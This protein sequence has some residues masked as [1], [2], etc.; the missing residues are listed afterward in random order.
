MNLTKARILLYGKCLGRYSEDGMH[1]ADFY[2]N[3]YD[4]SFCGMVHPKE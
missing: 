3:Q 4:C 2:D 1:S